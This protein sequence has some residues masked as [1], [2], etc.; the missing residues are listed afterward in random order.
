MDNQAIIN[1]HKKPLHLVFFT[2][3]ICTLLLPK[4]VFAEQYQLQLMV[5]LS[6]LN[7]FDANA[8]WLEPIVSPTNNGEFFV[9]QDNGRIYL[10][11]QNSKNIQ[12]TILNL[13]LITDDAAF[14][15]LT[16]M[17]LH[18]SF[19]RPK[20]AG[21]ATIFT[22][23]TTEFHQK[24]NNNQLTLKDTN[25]IFGFETVITAWQYDFD[26]QKIDPKTRREV[27]SIPIHKKDSGIRNL[28]F[29]SYQKSW[30]VD[31]GQ[32]YF[33]LNY[34]D[35]LKNY[36]LYSGVIL[37]IDPHVFGSLNYTVIESNPFIKDPQINK[38]IVLMG[39][40]NIEH[41]FW[42]KNDHSSIFIQHNNDEQHRLSKAILGDDLLTQPESNVFWQQ[43]N[44]MSAM[45]LYQGRDF[46]SLRNK[47]IFFTL[48]DKK[49]R[50]NSL[51]L[52]PLNNELP[53]FD[54]LL[55][56]DFLSPTSH[57]NIYQD[58]Q[59]QIIIFD[60]DK[61]K[62]YSLQLTISEIIESSTTP[63]E[64]NNYILYISSIVGLLLLLIFV[65]RKKMAGDSFDS[66]LHKDHLRL[67]YE[68]TT[69]TISLLKGSQK[70]DYK[71]LT[72]DD[73]I[74]C[75]ILLNNNI[76]NTI[77][78]QPENAL[79]N[80]IEADMRAT[81]SNEY[82]AK[83]HNEDTRH[84]EIVLSVKGDSFR[85]SLYL[86]K[87]H[88]RLTDTKYYEVID[89]LVD[90]CWSIS[91]YINPKHTETRVIP[92]IKYFHPSMNVS[93]RQS[94]KPPQKKHEKIEGTIQEPAEY[95]STASKHSNQVKSQTELVDMLDKLVNLH[96]QGYLSDKEFHLAKAKLLE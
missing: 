5:D 55:T 22:A 77:S 51:A 10:K 63:A 48:L 62:M 19:T 49:W 69:Q 79:S 96:Q 45:L 13:P 71:T 34:I 40:Q 31:Y 8:V 28:K 82:Y 72:L 84:I 21:Y 61:G 26:T 88:N 11:N 39:A 91:K 1:F 87:G 54:E 70:N 90:L 93:P 65:F 35:E 32:L 46:I 56:R 16:A 52:T 9:A 73:I 44:E 30:N 47:L 17:T 41:F 58:N 74:R 50:L 6:E 4:I 53:M 86:R 92:I 80:Q 15:T 59:G 20:K 66:R 81:F 36:P 75:E 18:P 68:P 76:I 25:I 38:E 94:S 12:K 37:R 7:D 57:F 83:M 95:T 67:E 89:I 2:M 60:N 27:L 24:T 64:S 42:S 29:D 14:I 85:A 23:H 3:A 43:P 33:S 78:E